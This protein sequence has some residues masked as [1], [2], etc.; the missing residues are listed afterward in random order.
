MSFLFLKQKRFFLSILNGR[1]H[2][3][4]SSTRGTP[5]LITFPDEHLLAEVSLLAVRFPALRRNG[6]PES[7]AIRHGLH[8]PESRHIDSTLSRSSDLWA[9]NERLRC[10]LKEGGTT[11]YRGKAITDDHHGAPVRSMFDHFG[12]LEQINLQKHPYAVVRWE[13]QKCCAWQRNSALSV[14]DV[15]A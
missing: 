3:T 15:T 14:W 6:Q 8:W 7:C 9:Q 4:P 2:T 13:M 1:A 5:P 11:A 12:P 10:P